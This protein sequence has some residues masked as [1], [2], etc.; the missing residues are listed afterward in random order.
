MSADDVELKKELRAIVDACARFNDRPRAK[1]YL[2]AAIRKHVRYAGLVELKKALA[3]IEAPIL[4]EDRKS[5]AASAIKSKAAGDA[6]KEDAIYHFMIRAL[7]VLDQVRAGGSF[8]DLVCQ[9]KILASQRDKIEGLPPLRRENHAVWAKLISDLT[10]FGCDLWVGG[11]LLPGGQIT[12]LI[13]QAAHTNLTKRKNKSIRNF[14]ALC[15]RTPNRFLRLGDSEMLKIEERRG[16]T[17]G[18]APGLWSEKAKRQAHKIESMKIG[19]GDW[20]AAL[21]SK[22][23][24]RLRTIVRDRS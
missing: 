10:A 23:D 12:K 3:T 8:A 4:E 18:E 19:P 21:R 24:E 9:D 14:T 20:E 1:A 11:D 16:P 17:N 5:R 15:G 13:M 6:V 7:G 22:I 2:E